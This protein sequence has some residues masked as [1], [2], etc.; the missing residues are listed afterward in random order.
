MT[1][2]TN[3]DNVFLCIGAKLGQYWGNKN[4]KPSTTRIE[5]YIVETAGVEPASKGPDTHLSTCVVY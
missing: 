4:K 5:S 1:L 3:L 2:S